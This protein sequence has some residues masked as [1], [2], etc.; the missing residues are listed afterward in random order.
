[1]I[2]SASGLEEFR[3]TRPTFVAARS[4]AASATLRG[5]WHVNVLQAGNYL[6]ELRRWPRH[7][8]RSLDAVTAEVAIAGVER[9]RKVD[10]AAAHATFRLKLPAGE[11]TLRSLLTTAEGKTRGAYFAYITRAD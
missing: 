11:T 7:L 1:M 5:Q 3:G 2:G 6:I 10:P 8:D 4:C 9:K